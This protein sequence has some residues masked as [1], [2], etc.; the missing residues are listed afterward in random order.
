[1]TIVRATRSY[2][3]WLARQIP[4]VP[5]DLKRKHHLMER[6]AFT[7]FRGTYYRWLERVL[8][9]RPELDGPVVACVGDLHAENFGTWTNNRGG[10]VW[11]VNDFD[12]SEV[13]PYTLDLARLA[14]SLSLA[15]RNRELDVAPADAHQAILDGYREA[16]TSGGAPFLLDGHQKLRTLVTRALPRPTRWWREL[17]ELPAAR[18]PPTGARHALAAESAGSEWSPRFRRRVAGVGSLGHRRFVALGQV[19]GRPEGRELKQ[20][21]LPAGRWLGRPAT[22]GALDEPIIRSGDPSRVVRAGWLVRRIAPECLKLDLNDLHTGGATRRVLR[23]MGQETANIHLGSGGRISAVVDDLA[24]RP[25]GWLHRAAHDLA[26]ATHED[27]DRWVR[28]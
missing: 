5:A 15:I 8:R 20:M 25:D 28:R 4:V 22:G 21:A 23:W 27:W 19:A 3:R 9:I 1:M 2:E 12:E 11:G 26:E 17:D 24:G 7:F 18:R 16:L 13:L 14:T 6:D 10:L